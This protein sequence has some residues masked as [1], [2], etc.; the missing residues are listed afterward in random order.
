MPAPTATAER[1]PDVNPSSGDGDQ[2]GPFADIRLFAAK[3]GTFLRDLTAIAADI[4]NSAVD[5]L[6]AADKLA[7]ATRWCISTTWPPSLVLE[8]G[9]LAQGAHP[10]KAVEARLL[11]YYRQNEWQ[12]LA[13]LVESTCQYRSLHRA[14]KRVLR[15]AVAMIRA[16]EAGGFNP[17]TFAVPRLFAELEG[18]LS[19]YS[20][21]LQAKQ[22]KPQRAGVKAIVAT[23]LPVASKIERP[24]L[25]LLRNQHF[26]TLP[27]FKAKPGRSLN[28]HRYAHGRVLAPTRITDAIRVLL[29]IDL[30]AFLIDLKM[31]WHCDHVDKRRLYA[32]SLSTLNRIGRDLQKAKLLETKPSDSNTVVPDPEQNT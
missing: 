31:K 26:K 9:A 28:R 32:V 5:L 23:L 12:E 24:S 25:R 7:R 22:R 19:E 27:N 13:A 20:A 21:L 2:R 18:L 4:A 14:R 6:H 1:A 11:D 16:G 17:A 8:I 29:L 3:I 10:R 30:S 15:D